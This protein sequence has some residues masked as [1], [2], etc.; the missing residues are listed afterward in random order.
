MMVRIS[1]LRDEELILNLTEGDAW[2]AV[3][4]GE[5]RRR[6]HMDD[7]HAAALSIALSHI[8]QAVMPLLEDSP[9]E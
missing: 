4:E 3:R 8:W 5:R 1:T 7:D 2:V 9:D 6:A